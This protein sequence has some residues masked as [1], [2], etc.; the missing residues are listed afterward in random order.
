[1]LSVLFDSFRE[2]DVM[3][4]PTQERVKHLFHY[5]PTTGKLY[6]KN[7]TSSRCK[8]G[9]EITYVNGGYLKVV[10]DGQL[11]LAHRVMWL[12]MT[13]HWPDYP[14][15]LVDHKDTNKLNNIFSNF[16]LTTHN[17]NQ[18]N[19]PLNKNSTTGCKGVTKVRNRYIAQA[20]LYGIKYY[21]G[22]F[23]TVEEAS[24]AYT[25]F[26]TARHDLP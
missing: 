26:V 9:Q 17:G 20:Q 25:A 2:N 22:S 13:G 16:R 5:N 24:S 6:W 7:P 8:P 18:H 23:S 4:K 10:F 19:R 15:E 3:Q 12:Y 14:K 1:M 11:Q 21:I